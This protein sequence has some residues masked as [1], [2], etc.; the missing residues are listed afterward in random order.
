MDTLVTSSKC[1]ELLEDVV[2]LFPQKKKRF[3]QLHSISNEAHCP[4]TVVTLRVRGV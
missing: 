1:H 2:L 3:A 4:I